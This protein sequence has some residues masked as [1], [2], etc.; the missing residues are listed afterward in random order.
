[1]NGKVKSAIKGAAIA[2]ALCSLIPIWPYRAF[3]SWEASQRL[4]VLP[5]AFISFILSIREEGFRWAF[6]DVIFFIN[7]IMLVFVCSVGAAIG[8]CRSRKSP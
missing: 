5:L 8:Y 4:G 2:T 3:S 7:F 1:M 6:F